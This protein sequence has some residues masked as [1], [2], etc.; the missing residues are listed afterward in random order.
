MSIYTL[1]TDDAGFETRVRDA[2]GPTLNGGLRRVPS[3][4]PG[5]P[6]ELDALAGARGSGTE[7]V[8]LGPGLDLDAALQLAQRF[9]MERPEISVLLVAPTAP[10]LLEKAL[11]AGVRDILAPDAPGADVHAVFE[12]AAAV[13]R[14]RF[15]ALGHG[16]E[17]GTGGRLITVISPKGGSGKTTTC[18]NLALGLAMA[19]PG[20]VVLVD[21][22]LQ[23]GDAASALQLDPETTMADIARAPTVEATAVKVALT[24]HASGLY[25]L[26]APDSP[27]EAEDITSEQVAATL[28][29]LTQEFRYVV[30]D[31][32][33]GLSEHALTAIESAT[34]LI[35][36]CSMDVPSIRGL[37]KELEALDLLELTSARRHFLL[38][39]ADARVGLDTAD[40]EATIRLPI[41][42]AIPSS[43]ALPLSLNQGT[44]V[45]QSDPRSTAARQ[46][47][48]LVNRF[49]DQPAQ[50]AGGGFLRRKK[51]A[52]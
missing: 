38:N 48:V 17:E 1:A 23:F 22:D 11:R 3:I 45:I 39:R 40:V 24:S 26:C 35:C 31:T 47:T 51:E 42:V 36:M 25:V 28:Q 32:D 49:T 5:S 9:D 2:F 15:G 4:D 50:R 37:R 29:V 27:A 13:A 16:P 19:D 34:D 10:G 30:V 43:R 41:D 20:Q 21:L 46:F 8:A 44:P 14:R 52:R 12:R 6:G 18:T 7:V 33:A